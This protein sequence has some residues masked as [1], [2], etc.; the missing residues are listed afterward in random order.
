MGNKLSLLLIMWWG[1]TFCLFADELTPEQMSF[2]S[3]IMQ[4][5]KEEGFSPTIDENDNSVMFK[6]EGH[7]HWIAIRDKNPFYVEFFRS[8]FA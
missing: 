5:L 3:N 7:L 1:C 4:F 6:K 2:R 8:G